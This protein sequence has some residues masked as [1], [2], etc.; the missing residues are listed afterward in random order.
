[1]TDSDFTDAIFSHFHENNSRYK[2]LW[3]STNTIS[4]YTTEFHIQ[5]NFCK[6][7]KLIKLPTGNWGKRE[8]TAFFFLI[9]YSIIAH[10]MRQ[11]QNS[12]P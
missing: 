1:M 2:P 11:N 5:I 8:Q 9:A 6:F 4:D 3:G 7:L 10:V 12:G